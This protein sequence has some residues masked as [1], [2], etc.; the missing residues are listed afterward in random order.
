ME[1]TPA[2]PPPASDPNDA[3]IVAARAAYTAAVE[4]PF[5]SE[6]HRL[7]AQQRFENAY[8]LK[9]PPSAPEAAPA[10]AAA[11]PGVTGLTPEATR[12]RITALRREYAQH[13]PG[14]PRY[15]AI[16]AEL[17]G[18]YK[19]LH[20]PEVAPETSE[21]KAAEREP[22]RLPD[23]PDGFSWD[24]AALMDVY[25]MVEREGLPKAEF[26]QGLALAA[27]L[28]AG[29]MPTFEEAE[30]TL[31]KTWGE[32]FDTKLK[33]ARG[34]VKRLPARVLDYLDATGLGDHPA[35]IE[36]FADLATRMPAGAG[37]KALP[38]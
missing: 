36:H 18:L 11:P 26:H 15:N 4:T 17:E 3:E 24:T 19:H 27:Q 30:S 34:V 35:M 12:A 21:G 6:A 20:P 31:R 38:E 14:S 9:Y 28:A 33:A 1:T 23:L 22:D 13:T 25:K 5:M 7:A 37:W 29:P 2:T 8:R 32:D 10:A 16:D